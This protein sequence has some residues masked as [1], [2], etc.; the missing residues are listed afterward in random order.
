MPEQDKNG[1]GFVL[2]WRK[3]W[4]NEFLKE[5]KPFSKREAWFYLFS[6]LAN[7]IDRN[8]IPRGQFEASYRFMAKKFRWS[9]NKT[10]RFISDLID[11]NM[12]KKASIP[13][14]QQIEHKTE[15]FIICEYETYNAI[16][17]TKQNTKQNKSNKGIN[18]DKNI[19][20]LKS[21]KSNGRRDEAYDIFAKLFEEK[22]GVK[23]Q[24]TIA[25]FKL[26]ADFRK[27]QDLPP[28]GIPGDWDTACRNYL[29]TPHES[30]TIKYLITGNRYP[31]YV[32]GSLDRYGK[33]KERDW[34]EDTEIED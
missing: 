30:Y 34:K 8:G 15:R 29:N 18:K 5:G 17:N 16:Q 26:L 3:V 11:Q 12:L 2:L 25:D 10:Y 6:N 19:D 1:K 4:D 20:L 23:Y 21:N 31:V 22:M 13:I 24:H 32:Q 33:P 9:T 28:K 7:G 27:S 14:E